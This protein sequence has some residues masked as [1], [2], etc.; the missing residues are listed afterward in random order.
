M[1][2]LKLFFYCDGERRF[3]GRNL[4]ECNSLRVT[5]NIYTAALNKFLQN[6]CVAQK[7]SGKYEMKNRIGKSTGIEKKMLQTECF[8]LYSIIHKLWI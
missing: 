5:K 7:T 2:Q 8:P 4:F 1:V 6:K 3:F